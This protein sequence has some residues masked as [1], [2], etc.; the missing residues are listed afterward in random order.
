MKK[1]K[2]MVVL[3]DAYYTGLELSTA[4]SLMQAEYDVLIWEPSP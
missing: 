1:N 4:L 3:L 2:S